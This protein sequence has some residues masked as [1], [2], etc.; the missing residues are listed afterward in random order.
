MTI[1]RSIAVYGFLAAI[2]VLLFSL[3]VQA[4]NGAEIVDISVS[5]DT[6]NLEVGFRLINCF[7]PKME[8]AIKSGV[9]TTFRF[10]MVLD[11]PGLP[12]F[13]SQILDNTLEHTIKYDLLKNEYHIQIP[14]HP[15]RIIRTRDFEEARQ[16]MSTVGNL[17]LIPLWRLEKGVTYELRLKAELSKSSLPVIYRYVFFFVSL[18]DFETAWYRVDI[19]R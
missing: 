12:P 1:I 8:E 5:L 13:R 2:C 19:S 3:P 7:T 9:K 11:K 16:W 17:P 18:W 14:E 10:R 4:K 15:D 6:G